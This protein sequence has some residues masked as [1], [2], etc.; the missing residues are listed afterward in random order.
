MEVCCC[1]LPKKNTQDETATTG[2]GGCLRR[3]GG[4]NGKNL[5]K[6]STEELPKQ[7]QKGKEETGWKYILLKVKNRKRQENGKMGNVVQASNMLTGEKCV[8]MVEPELIDEQDVPAL[9]VLLRKKVDL[10][11]SDVSI[12]IQIS[13]KMLKKQAKAM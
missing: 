8:L 1:H 3:K 9:E 5:V 13:E 12:F 7:N 11:P 2:N 6:S 10:A 4:E